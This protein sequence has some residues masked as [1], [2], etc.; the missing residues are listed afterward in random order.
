VARP[1]IVKVGGAYRTTDRIA[2]TRAYDLINSSLTQ[3][4]LQQSP[5]RIFDGQYAQESRLLLRAN[6]LAGSYLADD[7]VTSGFAMLEIPLGQRVKLIGGARVEK[8]DLTVLS[9]TVQGDT[10]EAS[11]NETDVL[12][13]V[14]LNIQLTDDQNLRFS[15]GK[16]V[17]RPEYRELSPVPY[18]EQVGLVTTFGNPDLQRATILNADVRWEWF[19][20]AGEVLSA[21]IFAKR[22]ED[23]GG[24]DGLHEH[25]PQETGQ[26]SAQGI[27]QR[28]DL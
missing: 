28:E 10:T 20:T 9:R 16:T 4:E 15:G 6:A 18:F 8:W 17:S 2:D 21:G 14:A 13:A 3:Q 22:F 19:P 1:V 7:Q 24:P 23:P 11:P 12:P 25:G 26:I 27:G 5:E